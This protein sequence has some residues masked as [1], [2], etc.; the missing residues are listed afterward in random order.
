[1]GRKRKVREAKT[2]ELLDVD[3]PP[4]IFGYVRVSTGKQL[5]GD[6]IEIQKK[7]ISDYC[8]KHLSVE[9][10]DGV[11]L[12][13]SDAASAWKRSLN[14]RQAGSQLIA[15][16]RKGDQVVISRLD[17]AFR[18]LADFCNTILKWNE[19]GIAFHITSLPGLH[20]GPFSR[21][22]LQML[23]VMAE[24][25]SSI[26]SARASE[27]YAH[28]RERFGG[29]SLSSAKSR[30][31]LAHQDPVSGEAVIRWDMVD[32]AIMAAELRKQGKGYRTISYA[33]SRAFDPS[34]KPGRSIRTTKAIINDSAACR[35][36]QQWYKFRETDLYKNAKR[37]GLT[38]L[39]LVGCASPAQEQTP[40]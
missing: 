37:P 3:R 2:H 35:I 18:S 17:R 23:G 6:S 28:R 26:R 8:E 12:W 20:S 7:I 10:P 30:F 15:N 13:F 32:I 39:E 36:L 5:N 4:C 16:L 24:L 33:M 11:S 38:A 31:C 27:S 1:M 25:E 22:M 19:Q 34:W 40:S 29:A 21:A 9:F 14:Q